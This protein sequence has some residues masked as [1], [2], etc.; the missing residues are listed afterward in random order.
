[1]SGG[2]IGREIHEIG[3]ASWALKGPVSFLEA[4]SWG[5]DRTE[6]RAQRDVEASREKDDLSTRLAPILVSATATPSTYGHRARRRLY[7][8][9][10]LPSF[11]LR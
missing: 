7:P 5:L 8:E 6:K 1:V 11:A 10:R 4:A 3:V 2:T 9:G